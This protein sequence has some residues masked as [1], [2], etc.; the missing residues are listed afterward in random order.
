MNREPATSHN[1]FDQVD[2]FNWLKA[3]ASPNWRVME[4]EQRIR[5]EVW[6]R[7]VFVAGEQS[8]EQGQEDVEDVLKAVGV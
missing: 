8:S 1:H 4:A 6:E 5:D 7:V 3:E 2:D